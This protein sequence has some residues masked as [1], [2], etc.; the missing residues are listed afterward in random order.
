MA[1]PAGHRFAAQNAVAM[2]DM[3]GESYLERVNCEYTSHI[4]GIMRANQCQLKTIYRSE[5]EDWIQNMV[6]GGM[7]IST[8]PEFSVVWPGLLSSPMIEPEVW[9]KICLLSMAGG[10]HSPAVASFVK[11]LRAFPF[12]DSRFVPQQQETVHSS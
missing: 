4:E 2:A 6:A 9:R 10:R 12:S 11:T 8:P 5:R 3:D 7:G 1:F